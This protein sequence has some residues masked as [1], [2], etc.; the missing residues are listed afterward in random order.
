[1]S[2]ETQPARYRIAPAGPF[3][4]ED[5][6][7]LFKEYE[8]YIGVDLSY[9]DFAAELSTLPGKYAPPGGQLLIARDAH[10]NAIGCVALRPLDD[11]C[12]EMKR[13]FVAPA[14]RGLGLGRALAS[15]IVDEA[16]RLG[17]AEMRL[18]TLPSMQAAISLY[19]ELGFVTID[20]YYATALPGTLFMART[21]A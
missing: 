18:D 13:L 4:V 11:R 7:R 12:C 5:I 9:Q 10:G 21:F 1:M 2:I 14:G 8:S 15:A 16:K 17:Y 19:K 3:D 20:L 6:A